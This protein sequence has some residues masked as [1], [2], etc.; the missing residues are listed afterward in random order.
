M[1]VAVSKATQHCHSGGEGGVRCKVESVEITFSLSFAS[2]PRNSVHHCR[3]I[4]EENQWRC[5]LGHV[6][7]DRNIINQ[8]T[9]Q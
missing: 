4:N 6:F 2:V 1:Y 9:G 8:M 5:V 7:S 3:K